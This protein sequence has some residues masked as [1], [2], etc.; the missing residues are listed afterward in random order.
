[1]KRGVVLWFLVLLVA[2][3]LLFPLSLFAGGAKEKE[4]SGDLAEPEGTV[5]EDWGWKSDTSPISFDWYFHVD[6]YTAEWSD[7]TY[8]S[9]LITDTTGV[10]VNIQ[11]PT[12]DP[13]ARLNLMIAS[14][15]LPDMVSIETWISQL[16]TVMGPEL[17]YSLYDLADKYDPYFY[18]ATFES[19]RKFWEQEDGE[20][21]GYPNTTVP[22]ELM[23]E[24]SKIS[25]SETIL[26][27]KDIY[28]AIGKPDMRLSLI[29]I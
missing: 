22:P 16:E 17:S 6:W 9:K 19:V 12:G 7:E 1:M 18:D 29:H 8:S 21:Y 23:N 28:E 11:T 13:D 24:D 26:V 3:G 15:S 4:S 10:S 2:V 14:D 27:R 5:G 25:S 20:L